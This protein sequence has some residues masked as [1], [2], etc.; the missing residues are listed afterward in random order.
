MRE[1]IEEMQSLR[2]AGLTYSQIG[3]RFGVS[4]QRIQ[5]L[6]APSDSIR[7]YVVSKYEERCRKCGLL[8]GSRGD[9]HHALSQC[10]TYNNISVLELL[11]RSCH[12]TEHGD[13][14]KKY[15]KCAQCGRNYTGSRRRFCSRSCRLQ[16]NRV[17][18]VCDV[19]GAIFDRKA[20]CVRQN[21]IHGRQNH[22]F[23]SK[24]CQGTFG[25]QMNKLRLEREMVDNP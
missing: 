16:W 7:R 22:I 2:R 25:G 24:K 14:K 17:T 10:D 1:H 13:Q 20:N 12:M 15:K 18:L 8:V 19:C 6:I 4:R 11:C 5:Q 23:C 21:I 9:V 3:Q